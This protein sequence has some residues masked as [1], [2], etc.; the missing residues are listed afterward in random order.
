MGQRPIGPCREEFLMRRRQLLLCIALASACG[1]AT[2][3]LSLAKNPH[4]NN[5]HDLLGAKLNQD[6][7]HEVG[8]IASNSVTAEVKGKKVVGMTAGNLTPR[9]V[10]SNKKMAGQPLDDVKVAV[11]GAIRLAQAD[12]YY[13]YC[14]DSGVDEYCY[15]YP[16]TD[17]VVTDVWVVYTP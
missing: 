3:Q 2:V 10:K 12:V 4:H 9:K 1:L 17:V 5:G 16:A 14:F 13:A 7:K 11:N 15:W 8:K 6:G